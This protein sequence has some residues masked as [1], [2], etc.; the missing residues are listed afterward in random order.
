MKRASILLAAL[1]ALTGAARATGLTGYA[2]Q[3]WGLTVLTGPAICGTA[4]PPA[5]SNFILLVDN[6]SFIL[7]TDNTSKICL[8]GGC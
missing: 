3:G 5:G 8:A 1:I 4:P 6:T 2:C 7:Q